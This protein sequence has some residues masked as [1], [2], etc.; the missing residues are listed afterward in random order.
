MMRG[1]ALLLAATLCTP[2][3]A[4]EQSPAPAPK[5]AEEKKICRT[6]IATGSLVQKNR[7]CRTR[8][9]WEATTRNARKEASDMQN[10][11]YSC[12]ATTPGVC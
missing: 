4:A 12:G 8:A 6:Y 3:A 10:P 1:M 9:E 5:P 7:I 2:A 11:A